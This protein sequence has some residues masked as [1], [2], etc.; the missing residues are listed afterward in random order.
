MCASSGLW[1]ASWGVLGVVPR[2]SCPAASQAPLAVSV[3]LLGRL[4]RSGAWAQ[5]FATGDRGLGRGV[6]V[7]APLRYREVAVLIGIWQSL[8]RQHFTSP[9]APQRARGHGGGHVQTYTHIN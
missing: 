6:A 4:R 8:F 9:A 1:L 2:P 5:R 3:A 7:P